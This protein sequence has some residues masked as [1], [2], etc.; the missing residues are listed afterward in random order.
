MPVKCQ[1]LPCNIVSGQCCLGRFVDCWSL[2]NQK[3]RLKYWSVN[4]SNGIYLCAMCIAKMGNR[5][6]SV[7]WTRNSWSFYF[8]KIKDALSWFSKVKVTRGKWWA[9]CSISETKT[10]FFG[11]PGKLFNVECDS[12][13]L[14]LFNFCF[15]SVSWG[16]NESR[17]VCS[18]DYKRVNTKLDSSYN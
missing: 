14:N 8:R 16:A 3:Y 12:F 2:G 4:F 11:N 17:W 9:R 13:P 7:T 5:R 6:Q 1:H 10:C 18:V 15:D